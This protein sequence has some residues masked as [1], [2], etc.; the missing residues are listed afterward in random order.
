MS[1]EFKVL[2]C[3]EYK[4]P[5][6]DVVLLSIPSTTAESLSVYI[7]EKIV[8]ELGDI[9]TLEYIEVKVNEGIGQGASYRHIINE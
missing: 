8:E 2:D 7:A 6:E 4:L 3:L 1:I 5:K 9:D